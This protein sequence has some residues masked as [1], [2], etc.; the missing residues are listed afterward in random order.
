MVSG[1]SPVIIPYSKIFCYPLGTILENFQGDHSVV[2]AYVWG[3]TGLVRLLDFA[4]SRQMS[5]T[6]ESNHLR[7]K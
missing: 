5:S 7:Q 2:P 3:A 4:V 1:N 6:L